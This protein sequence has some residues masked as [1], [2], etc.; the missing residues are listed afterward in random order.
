MDALLRAPHASDASVDV[1]PDE[2]VDAIVPEPA[3]VPNAEKLAA[4]AR[5]VRA[6]GAAEHQAQPEEARA[7]YKQGAGRSAA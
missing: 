4:R 7:L 2:A 3:G 1:H 5:V 6:P